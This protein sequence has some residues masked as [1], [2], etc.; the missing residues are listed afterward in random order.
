[1]KAPLAAAA[2]LTLLLSP[3]T[4][5]ASGWWDADESGNWSGE[6]RWQGGV[7]ADGADSVAR[8]EAALTAS[9][10][11]TN[12][13][14]TGGWSGV[15]GHLR[16]DNLGSGFGWNL[17]GDTLALS[18]TVGTPTIT[19]ATGTEVTLSS[20]LAGTG[21]FAKE[22]SGTLILTGANHY[23]GGTTVNAGTLSLRGPGGQITASPVTV[24]SGASLEI[25]PAGA[26]R[27]G[28]TL[29]LYLNDARLT[30]GSTTVTGLNRETIGQVHFSGNATLA[31]VRSTSGVQANNR[32][33]LTVSGF[34]QSDRGFLT[35]LPMAVMGD[36][37][38]VSTSFRFEYSLTETPETTHGI[39]GPSYVSASTTSH[40]ADYV[41]FVADPEGGT[42]A[43]WLETANYT[44][45]SNNEAFKENSGQD[46]VAATGN[47]AMIVGTEDYSYA[48]F[49]TTR[50]I[51]GTTGTLTL[52]TGGLI[53]TGGSSLFD[54]ISANIDFGT[55]AMVYA[56]HSQAVT[57]SG[58]YTATN[59]FTKG[60]YSTI[61]VTG[62]ENDFGGGAVTIAE[63]ILRL[64]GGNDR[65]PTDSAL[66]VHH[67]GTFDLAGLSQ[68]VANLDG[69]GLITNS[70]ASTSG[71]I[72]IANA[73]PGT[74]AGTVADGD[75][76]L[77]LT[78]S[79]IGTLIL[80]GANTYSGTTL[81][82]GGVLLVNGDQSAATGAV[83]V[84]TGATLGGSG[85]IG[86]ATTIEGTLAPGNSAGLLTFADDLTLEGGALTTFEIG[87]NTVRGITYD[88]VDIGGF[89]TYGGDLALSI[90]GLHTY[91]TWDLFRFGEGEWSENFNTITL[92][93]SYNGTLSFD[94]T[95]WSGV[96][97]G[98]LWRFDQSI[99]QLA[100]VPEPST[101]VALG[102]GIA[103][104]ALWRRRRR[105][106]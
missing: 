27:Y 9:R 22:G 1:M 4:Q 60:G 21:G 70:A 63:G 30:V 68:Q 96:V 103:L 67:A 92:T 89:L 45:L 56:A 29:S 102:T 7:V 72:T 93:G 84:A 52:T 66:T 53:I 98:Q 43:G 83:A 37:T 54:L 71:R 16:F 49:R 106:A 105:V 24:N 74:F 32:T 36:I 31:L 38:P 82:T 25:V 26:D 47:N 59:G 99:G 97:D 50:D 73:T 17:A 6:T 2:L 40:S 46:A 57:M 12:D 90:D 41:R 33:G 81:V 3:S 85:V 11:I 104:I 20:S 13:A 69:T 88:A 44:A 94:G 77:G 10:T 55:E 23:T 64:G 28:D 61:V 100:A 87:L 78:K 42:R 14:G 65:L 75:G 8:F 95:L 58:R 48:A 51:T 15:I 91:A 101:W 62:A 39:L 86:G 18:T 35:F 80:S 5:A 19:T 34:T 79:G 76:A